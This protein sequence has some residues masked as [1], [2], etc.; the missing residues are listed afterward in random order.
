MFRGAEIERVLVSEASEDYE[1][2]AAFVTLD[3]AATGPFAVLE[4]GVRNHP[5]HE[6]D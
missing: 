2:D 1:D 3:S 6:R 4:E 5:R